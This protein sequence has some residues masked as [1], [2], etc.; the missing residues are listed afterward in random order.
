MDGESD[1][2]MAVWINAS[3]NGFVDKSL[4][5]WMD[6]YKVRMVGGWLVLCMDGKTITWVDGNEV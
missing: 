6:G 5:G 1:E 4:D 2:L 3:T